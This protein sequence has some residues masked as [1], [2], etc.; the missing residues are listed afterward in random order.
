MFVLAHINE[1]VR[2][3]TLTGNMQNIYS[4]KFCWAEPKFLDFN[5]LPKSKIPDLKTPKVE[6]YKNIEGSLNEEE[7]GYDII[8]SFTN[9][10]MKLLQGLIY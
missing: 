2:T 7:A 3:M 4:I 8:T 9:Y 6:I 5:F 10:V 1:I